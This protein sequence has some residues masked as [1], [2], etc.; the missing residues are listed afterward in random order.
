M[1]IGEQFIKF[2]KCCYTDIYSCINNNGFTTNWFQLRK[3]VRQGCPLSC[4]LFILCVEIIGNQIRSYSNIKGLKIGKNEHKLKQ[5]A[6]DCSC[7]I[8]N[9]ESIYTLIETIKGFTAHSGLRLNAEKSILFFL[10]PWKNKIINI[11][12]MRVERFTLNLLGIEI[13]RCKRIKQER[14]FEDKIPKLVNQLHMHSQRDLS[15]YGKIL[16]TKTFGISK[17]IHSIAITDIDESLIK[18]VP[19]E[20]NK[21]I[22]TYKPPKVKHNVIIGNINQ[23]G[24]GAID[25]ESKCKALRLPWLQRIINGNGWNDIINEYLE[26]IGGINFL[27][28]CNF[29]SKYLN[30]IPCFYRKLLEFTKEIVYSEISESIIWNNKAIRIENKSIFWKELYNKGIVFIHDFRSSTGGW[31]GFDEFCSYYDMHTNFL[32]YFGILSA[33]KHAATYL[34]VDLSIK[35][36]LNIQSTNFRLNSGK[37]I[38]INKAKSKNF[39]NEYIE[40]NLEPASALRKWRIEYSLDEGIFYQSLPLAKQCTKEPKLLAFQFK[41]IH[42]IVNCRSNLRK[43]NI[44]DSD[45]C[46]FCLHDVPDNII[47]ALCQC[48]YSTKFVTD[49]FSLIDPQN[50]CANTIQNADFLFG[51]DDPALNVVFLILKKY[52][53]NV[54]TDK[55]TFSLNNAM[56]Q[57]YRRF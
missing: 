44:S 5:F 10:G 17:I 15:L 57:I 3:S 23:G 37:I 4:L 19:S 16:L 13:G 32:K 42:N 43:W 8:R 2:V 36:T 41:L 30:W 51:V 6:D 12:D 28:R 9:I 20:F 33:I 53:M 11:L 7:F 31:M 26:P 52:I 27:I 1:N 34:N 24:L 39:Y 54:R 22:W 35:P 38:D 48:E 50:D 14:N 29:D 25:M 46:E 40:F 21:Y 45:T 47:H 56:N 55:N 49:I 18:V